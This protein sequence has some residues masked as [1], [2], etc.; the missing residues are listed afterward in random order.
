MLTLRGSCHEWYSILQNVSEY[1]RQ[2]HVDVVA[3]SNRSIIAMY[4]V[5]ILVPSYMK[6][7][8]HHY[9]MGYNISLSGNDYVIVYGMRTPLVQ[10][11][12]CEDVRSLL[13][14]Q[15]RYPLIQSFSDID[16]YLQ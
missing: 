13:K 8:I 11:Q 16:I 1:A 3:N 12:L 7:Y 5:P 9:R 15:M 2:L 10:F 6:V 14:R 4:N